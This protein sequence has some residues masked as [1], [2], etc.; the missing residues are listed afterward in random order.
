LTGATGGTG[1]TGAT[2]NTGSTG[3]TGPSGGTGPSGPTGDTGPTGPVGGLNPPQV[4]RGYTTPSVRVPA[5]RVLTGAK[6]RCLEG[7][8]TIRKIQVRFVVGNKVFNGVGRGPETVA[9]GRTAQLRVT[10]PIGLYG[11]LKR[12]RETSGTVTFIVTVTSSNGTRTLSSNIRT[13]LRR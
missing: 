3:A 13:G 2:G 7:I 4:L 10:M 9:A 5:N 1:A 12:R 8:C 6:V 11:D